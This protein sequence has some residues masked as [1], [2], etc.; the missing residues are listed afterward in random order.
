MLA[1]MLLIAAA[2]MEELNIALNLC[3]DRTRVACKGVRIWQAAYRSTALILLKTGMGPKRSGGALRRTLCC[4][5][6]A[7]ILVIGYAGS[8]SEELRAGDLAVL[9]C[10]S[11]LGPEAVPIEQ[12]SL[13][14]SWNLARG[15]DLLETARAGG[16]AASLCDGL[17]SPHIVGEPSQKRLLQER[18]GAA[19]IDMETAALAREA[20]SAGIPLCCVRSVSDEL[21]DKFLAPFAY[22]GVSSSLSRAARVVSAGNWLGRY[23][24][25]RSRAA[26][27]KESLRRF[28]TARLS[29][30]S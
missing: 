12:T 16:A 10:V 27:A 14:G 25:W 15:A 4:L 22:D 30:L 23:S 8:L 18:F 13:T 11:L 3:T 6:P 28:L 24:A 2:L 19:V 1:P 20:A 17:T 21:D 26:L 7:E 5:R 29:M 9:R